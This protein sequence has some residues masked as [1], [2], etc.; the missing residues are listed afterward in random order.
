[1][2][3]TV[4]EIGTAWSNPNMASGYSA[5]ER[6]RERKLVK[7]FE[8][9]A[10]APAMGFAST[11]MDLAK[12][13]SWQ[14][15]LLENGGQYILDSTSL[16]EMHRVHWIDPDWKITWGLGFS[17]VRRD[18]KTFVRHGGSCPGFRSEFLLQT[19]DNIA[20]V[21]MINANGTNPGLLARRTY[22]IISPALKTAKK[23]TEKV[24]TLQPEFEK[25]VGVYNEYPW[26]GESAVFP[27]E[28]GL[29]AI[30]F[31]T[32]DPLKAITKFKHVDGNRF[33]RIRSDE[34]LGEEITFEIDS[35]GNV[36]R[37]WWHNNPYERISANSY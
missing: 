9:N 33:R 7:H 3:S 23:G 15:N 12:F 27:W 29:A 10:I 17:V 4:S 30:S 18:E 11:V 25:Y 24:E 14:F 13:A 6:D 31:P 36:L 16:R 28:G 1:M 5:E 22:E 20:V 35:T 2:T 34:S 26:G 37:M 19:D 32:N 8:G 21:V